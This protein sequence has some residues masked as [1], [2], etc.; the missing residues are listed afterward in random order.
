LYPVLSTGLKDTLGFF[1]IVTVFRYRIEALFH[2]YGALYELNNVGI[3]L[4][5]NDCGNAAWP[6]NDGYLGT[7]YLKINVRVPGKARNGEKAEHPR[8]M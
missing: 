8:S 5:S 6:V 7:S 4:E 3:C 2:A 1:T